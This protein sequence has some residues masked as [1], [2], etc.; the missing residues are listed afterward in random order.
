[1]SQKSINICLS[2]DI[3]HLY[4]LKDTIV[5]VTDIFRATSCMV[6]GLHH[7]IESITPVATVKECADLQANGYIAAAE[8]DA[9][10]VDGFELDN[11]PFSYMNPVLKGK[12]IA[13]TTTNGTVS[14]SKVKNHAAEVLI[15]A[16]LNIET[17]AAYLAKSNMNVLVLCA[18]WKGTPSLEDTL[19]GG[20]LVSDL[21]GNFNIADDSATM[22][23]RLY[24]EGKSDLKGYLQEASHLKRLSGLGIDKDIDFCLTREL[25]SVLPI[26]INDRLVL[27]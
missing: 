13:M 8:R 27:K 14:I 20:A 11:S 18:G 1:M 22:A 5:V 2:P 23:C 15:G 9:K 25:Y 4:E 16:F 6:T 12:K 21:K 24:S 3:I 19:F 10:K 7:G 17:V 26:L